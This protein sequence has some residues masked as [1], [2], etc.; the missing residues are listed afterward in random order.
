M[1]NKTRSVHNIYQLEGLVHG[2]ED[3]AEAL[4]PPTTRSMFNGMA[5]GSSTGQQR[6]EA[7]PKQL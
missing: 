5:N 6:S 1:S 4:H 2:Q 3:V 7:V